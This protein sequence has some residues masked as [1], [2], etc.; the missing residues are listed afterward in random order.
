MKKKRETKRIRKI[1]KVGGH[2]VDLNLEQLAHALESLTIGEI[3]TLEIM[4]NPEL[5]KELKGRWEV[6]RKEFAQGEVIS[7]DE[8]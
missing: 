2:S 5:R 8:L 1:T 7:E 4:L 6:G 3:E